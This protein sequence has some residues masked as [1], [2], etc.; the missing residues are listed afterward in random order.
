MESLDNRPAREQ[1][2]ILEVISDQNLLYFY[3]SELVQ[4]EKGGR[5]LNLLPK[6]VVRKFIR[7]GVLNRFA[8]K[9]HKYVL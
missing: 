1:S 2:D 6:N 8:R 4:I 5:A 9:S 3:K 7:M